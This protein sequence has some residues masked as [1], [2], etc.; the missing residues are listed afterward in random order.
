MHVAEAVDGTF[1]SI[2]KMVY[3]NGQPSAKH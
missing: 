2:S 3:D 1:C